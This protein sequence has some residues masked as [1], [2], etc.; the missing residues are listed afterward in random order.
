MIIIVIQNSDTD[1]VVGNTPEEAE[2]RLLNWVHRHWDVDLGEKFGD[3]SDIKYYQE[4]TQ[5]KIRIFVDEI[6][7]QGA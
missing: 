2:G 3:V 1:I 5:A 4:K 7:K 6:H